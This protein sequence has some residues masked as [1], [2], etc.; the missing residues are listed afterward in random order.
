MKKEKNK[1]KNKRLVLVFLLFFFR[2]KKAFLFLKSSKK[3]KQ[4]IIEIHKK[5]HALMHSKMMRKKLQKKKSQT[6]FG[7]SLYERVGALIP[8]VKKTK[9]NIKE[10]V[11][12][13]I[14]ETVITIKGTIEFYIIDKAQ[15]K[16]IFAEKASERQISSL[17]V[18]KDISELKT[19]TLNTKMLE[20]ISDEI[21]GDSP[22]LS[23][24]FGNLPMKSNGLVKK[25]TN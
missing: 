5:I 25:T 10:I 23:K 15:E 11:T 16:H 22:Y 3:I 21:I 14:K 18:K 6:I 1:F 19:H 20:K 24:Y 4:A 17:I 13:F 2:I 12:N 9:S 7:A 8:A